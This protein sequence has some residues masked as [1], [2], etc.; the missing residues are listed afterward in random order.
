MANPHH[1]A[2]QVEHLTRKLN[3]ITRVL[4]VLDYGVIWLAIFEFSLRLAS[5]RLDL[6]PSVRR[7]LDEDPTGVMCVFDH[8]LA[9]GQLQRGG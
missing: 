7:A 2:L 6:Q 4:N 9:N 1:V 8:E 3:I 5:H